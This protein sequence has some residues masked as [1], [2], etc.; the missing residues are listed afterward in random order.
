MKL[1]LLLITFLL[2]HL[3]VS[4]QSDSASR[5]YTVKGY[6]EPYFSFQPSGEE[7]EKR[8]FYNYRRSNTLSL[9]LALLSFNYTSAR[10]KA[11]LSVQAGDFSTF[12]YAAEPALFRHVYQATAEYTISPKVSITGGIFPSHIGTE[13][14]IGKDQE[15]LTRSFSAENTP[16]YETGIKLNYAPNSRLTLMA[17]LLNGW[18]RIRDN[19][20][21][22]AFGS[23][24]IYKPNTRL[25]LNSSSYIGNDQPQGSA[26]KVRYFHDLYAV[27]A[28]STK[29]SAV[30]SFDIGA[31]HNLRK[32]FDWWYNPTLKFRYQWSKRLYTGFRAEYFSDPEQVII[33]TG[34]DRG[35][36]ALGYSAN[37]DIA[38]SKNVLF[39]TEA[40][41]LRG[42]YPVK[43]TSAHTGKNFYFY[44]S[45]LCLSF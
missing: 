1:K 18:Q 21:W 33:S 39:R 17:A 26:G 40:R 10:W 37:A 25:L 32:S 24:I 7:S 9:N 23:Q 36:R 8:L 43:Y 34:T 30:A 13:S 42:K 12:N 11:M 35:I 3:H 15:N 22:P 28:L 45:S 2:Y 5:R 29:A 44:T 19:N 38:I 16:Y 31:Q 41:F 14:A 27:V 4:A 20:H 6:A